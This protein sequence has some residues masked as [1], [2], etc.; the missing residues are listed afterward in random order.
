VS[1][2]VVHA[3]EITVA[4][5]RQRLG[6]HDAH[7]QRAHEPRPLGHRDRFHGAPPHAR[8]RQRAVHHRGKRRQMR[9]ARELGHNA[10][11]HLVDVLGQDDEA[12]ELRAAGLAHEHCR[13][14]LV[15]RRFD[16]EDDLSH[17]RPCA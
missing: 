1:F 4:G 5:I 17:G 3:D 7:E 2:H 15:A 16:A 6:V 13:R 8:F 10:A 11:E 9:A 12:R 14:G